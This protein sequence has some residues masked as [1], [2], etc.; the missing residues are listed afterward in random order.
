METQRQIITVEVDGKAEFWTI[1]MEVMGPDNV[2]L[3][4]THK[5]VSQDV[6]PV[7]VATRAIRLWNQWMQQ[8]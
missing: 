2:L 6:L 4:A 5:G 8:L 7:Q 1:G 3:E